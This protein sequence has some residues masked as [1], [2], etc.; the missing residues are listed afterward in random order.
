MAMDRKTA[1]GLCLCPRCPTFVK[2]NE[3]IAFCLSPAGTSACIKTEKGCLC[4]GCPVQDSEGFTHVYYCIRG[5]E[6]AQLR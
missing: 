5:S 2:C 1:T 6:A 4:P 3:E